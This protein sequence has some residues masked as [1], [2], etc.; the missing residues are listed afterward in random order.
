VDT[1][2]RRHGPRSTSQ[3]FAHRA[4]Y[5]VE[6]SLPIAGLLIAI[7]AYNFFALPPIAI[8]GLCLQCLSCT[9][10]RLNSNDAAVTEATERKTPEPGNG[11][12]LALVQKSG[13]K[14]VVADLDYGQYDRADGD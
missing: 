11:N 12:C 4:T 14:R 5:A 3:A 1:V 8:I 7:L 6:A 2:A 10:P 9:C 13:G